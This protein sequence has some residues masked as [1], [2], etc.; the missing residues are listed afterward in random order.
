MIAG[1][2]LP[3]RPQALLLDAGDTLVF[4]DGAAVA[5]QLAANGELVAADRLNAALAPAKRGYQ[6]R[7][8]FG[9]SH[10]DGWHA[11]MAD[12]LVLSG[13]REARARELVP[14]L[15]RAQDDFNFWRR[16]PDGTPEALARVREAGIRLAVISNSE[17]KL[18]S[19]FERVGLGGLFEAVVDSHFEGVRK[20]DPELFRR[21]IARLS[22]VP[23][24][25]L[26]AGDIPEVDVL[27][28]RAAGLHGVLVDAAG[29]FAD[30]PWPRVG[31]V[32]ELVDE[33]LRLPA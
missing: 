25:C 4:F 20:P 13:V 18:E 6:A 24:R 31:S 2:T 7:M 15:R 17:G 33:L 1:L 22:L 3:R 26:Y 9:D 11:L 5:E 19:L 23:E 21:A 8:R 29:Q 16:V 28:A 10:E 27:G 32:V 30:G 12:V 14:E